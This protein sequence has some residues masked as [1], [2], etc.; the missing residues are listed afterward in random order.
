[1]IQKIANLFDRLTREELLQL[2][3][4]LEQKIKN[5]FKKDLGGRIS[6]RVPVKISA[7]MIIE[8]EKEFFIQEHKIT[9][10]DMSTHGLAF[11]TTSTVYKNDLLYIAF[12]SPSSWITKEIDCVTVRI[13][14]LENKN[15]FKVSAKSVDKTEVKVYRDMLRRRGS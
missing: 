9:I 15:E 11:H 13:K 8:R 1:M 3:E 5:K 14:K 10:V 2:K 7:T 6:K 12:R 4:I